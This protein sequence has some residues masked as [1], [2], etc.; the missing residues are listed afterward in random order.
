MNDLMLMMKMR[1]HGDNREDLAGFLGIHPHT[2]Y[3][4]MSDKQGQQFTQSEIRRI[5]ERYRLNSDEIVKI[6]FN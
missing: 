5:T 1:E 2:L 4:K 6:F 3:M